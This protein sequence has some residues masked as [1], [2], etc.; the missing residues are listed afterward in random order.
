LTES[1]KIEE[2]LLAHARILLKVISE[3]NI[4]FEYKEFDSGAILLDI[5]IN[6]KMYCIQMADN[7]FGWSRLD[8]ETAF[9]S[10]PDSGY[11]NWNT[12]KPQFD[13]VVNNSM[14]HNKRGWLFELF[15]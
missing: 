13:R 10:L 12:F 6:T 5:W 7:R 3:R 1:I 15:N 9:C 2:D 11:L 14:K 4:K 8:E